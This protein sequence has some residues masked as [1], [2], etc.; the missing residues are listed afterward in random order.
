VRLVVHATVVV[1][2]EGFTRLPRKFLPPIV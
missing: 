1:K 2:E